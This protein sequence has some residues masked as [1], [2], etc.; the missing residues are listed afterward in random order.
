MYILACACETLYA[1]L[2]ALFFQRFLFCLQKLIV[3]E[4]GFKFY[5]KNLPRGRLEMPGNLK[6]PSTGR[7]AGVQTKRRSVF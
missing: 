7:Q 1:F 2:L 5:I 4:L 3:F 6:F